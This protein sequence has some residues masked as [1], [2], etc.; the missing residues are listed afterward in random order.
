MPDDPHQ[1]TLEAFGMKICTCPESLRKAQELPKDWALLVRSC[2]IHG[3]EG[4]HNNTPEEYHYEKSEK[5]ALW[6]G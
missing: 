4:E 2:P 1:T 3:E 5:D 6:G